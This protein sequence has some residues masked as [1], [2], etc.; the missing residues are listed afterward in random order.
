MAWSITEVARLAPVTSRT[1]RHYHQ[2]GLLAPAYVG[3]NGRRYYEQE[4]L[5]R[6]QSVLLLRELGVG[7]AT[8]GEVLDG[9]LDRTTALREHEQTLHAEQQRLGRLA[10]TVTRTIAQ[11][12]GGNTM[13][14][15]E[16]FDGFA[17]RKS[18]FEDE[19]AGRY[20]EGVRQH[21][22]ESSERTKNWT[23]Q[24]YLQSKAD[25]EELDRRFVQLLRSGAAPDSDQALE[26]T[27]EHYQSVSAFWT[28]DRN[29]FRELGRLYADSP[30]F[31]SRYDALDPGLAEYLRDALAA[32]AE[33]V[34]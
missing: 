21:F 27:A 8:I 9:R 10:D 13:S 19:L 17:Q 20:G 7:L 5:L 3:H 6:L 24:D 31:R 11:L 22:T 33:Q 28:P 2:I 12:E 34:L 15:A 14:A 18:A 25:G 30:D 23:E 32:Y 1:L 4:Q 29:S 26:L 16:L